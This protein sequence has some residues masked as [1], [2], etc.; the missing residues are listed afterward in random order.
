MHR[1]PPTRTAFEEKNVRIMKK[2]MNDCKKKKPEEFCLKVLF[3]ADYFW[4]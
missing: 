1:H 4:N 2:I 3:D